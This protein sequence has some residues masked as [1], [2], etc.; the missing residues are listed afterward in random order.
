MKYEDLDVK[1]HNIKK[2]MLFEKHE[3]IKYHSM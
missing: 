3:Q 1:K 2:E